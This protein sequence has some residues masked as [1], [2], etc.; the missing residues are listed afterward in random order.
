MLLLLASAQAALCLMYCLCLMCVRVRLSSLRGRFRSDS[1]L[2]QLPQWVRPFV[3]VYEN[4]G[5]CQ[6]SLTRFFKAAGT[7]TVLQSNRKKVPPI[8]SAPHSFAPEELGRGTASH[9]VSDLFTVAR[10]QRRHVPVI[11]STS[12]RDHSF[13][14]VSRQQ[15]LFFAEQPPLR[16]VA[17]L[18][19]SLSQHQVCSCVSRASVLSALA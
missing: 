7:N 19:E 18:F 9:D 6:G 4:F 8:S 5:E 17:S 14:R 12:N 10:T 11:E 3:T 15:P 13:P 1:N 2:R 16:K